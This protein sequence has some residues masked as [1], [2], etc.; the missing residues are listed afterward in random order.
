MTRH[1][2]PDEAAVRAALH[3]LG[4]RPAGHAPAADAEQQP[5]SV[6]V[7]IPPLP[8]YE[9]TVPGRSRVLTPRLPDWRDPHKP[10]LG[11]VG[12]EAEDVD[13]G[14]ELHGAEEEDITDA[15]E[16][17]PAESR[18]RR[19]LGLAKG[20]RDE[21]GGGNGRAEQHRPQHGG[22]SKE[23]AANQ[24]EE[25]EDDDAE[26]LEEVRRVGERRARRR[27][28]GAPPSARGRPRLSTPVFPRQE[29]ERK[30]FAQAWRE[31]DPATKWGLYHVSGL[32]GGLA[33]GVVSFATDVTRSV[34]ESPLPLRENPDAYFW[35]AGAVL[36]LALDRVTR[37]WAWL[38]GWCTRGVTASL[39]IGALLH[40][41]TVG[42]ALAH[43]PT[44]L[45]NL[46]DR[47]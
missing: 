37:R 26:D 4:A 28:A 36:V 15:P 21:H 46:P 2:E 8:A 34:A 40:G 41:Y 9:P 39:I 7:V 10:E 12:G 38:V 25:R 27:R 24:G 29:K 42:E 6:A 45:D 31:I 30:S 43:M 22:I 16:Q 44:L 17:L 18:R 11:N 13:G 14:E 20:E 33:F 23:P 3:R 1:S 35:T 47:P 5:A 19:L 32:V